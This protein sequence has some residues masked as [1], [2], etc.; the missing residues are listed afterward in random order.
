MDFVLSNLR[1]AELVAVVKMNRAFYEDFIAYLQSSGYNSPQDLV[2]EKIDA[3]AIEVIS[4]F[5]VRTS[6][7]ELLNG[8]GNPY[9]NPQARWYFLAWILRDAPAQRLGPLLKQ[10][11]GD[12]PES[13]KAYL[14]N[15]V[16]KFVA[17]LFPEYESWT[18][19]A[20]SEVILARLE[21]SRRA[22]KG[23]LFEAVVRNCL[24]SVFKEYG[25]A[26]SVGEKEVRIHNETYDVQVSGP[27]R[28]ILIPVKTRE[29]M[30]GG[31]AMLFTRDI[32][33]SISVAEANGYTCLPIVIAESWGGDLE[34]LKSETF[35]YIQANPNQIAIIEPQLI[36]R[37][38]KLVPLFKELASQ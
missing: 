7:A 26:L 12:N 8:V 29:T 32:R 33:E 15:E 18:W 24:R 21:G 1:L 13:R 17:P 5:L 27:H 34:S 3:R 30:G 22:L 16:R 28:S 10:V 36:E 2:N 19:P 38:K 9:P 31:H 23:G 25:I 14:L 11:P 20:I 4:G 37:L 35:I 6:E